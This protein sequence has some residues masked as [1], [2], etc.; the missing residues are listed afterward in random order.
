MTSLSG[1]VLPERSSRHDSVKTPRHKGLL[2]EA[3][4]DY[5]TLEDTPQDLLN[6]RY[7]SAETQDWHYTAIHNAD[8]ELEYLRGKVVEGTSAVNSCVALRGTPAD[9]DEWATLGNDARAWQEVLPYFWR[10]GA[11]VAV[12]VSAAVAQT[13]HF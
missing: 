5:T 3:G 1:Q 6:S 9:Y 10:S 12:R 4:P 2:V 11:R 8:R 13:E 7:P